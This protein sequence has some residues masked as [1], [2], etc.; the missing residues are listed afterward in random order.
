MVHQ[1]SKSQGHEVEDQELYHLSFGVESTF[2]F[3]CFGSTLVILILT[4]PFDGLGLV[5]LWGL[6][7]EYL[8]VWGV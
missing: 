1:L 4:V 5:F 2:W 6:D 7:A 3:Y 8:F